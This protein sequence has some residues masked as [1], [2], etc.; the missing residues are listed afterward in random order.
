MSAAAGVRSSSPRNF[1][2]FTAR[3]PNRPRRGATFPSAHQEL[4]A[5]I[6]LDL[7]HLSFL[8][9]YPSHLSAE[10][11]LAAI[12]GAGAASILSREKL[13]WE[14]SAVSTFY[15]LPSRP[16]LGERFA[17]Y[18]KTLFPGLDWGSQRWSEL[19]DALADVAGKQPDVYVVYREEL[20]EGEDTTSALS[21]GFGALAGD[22]VVEILSGEKPSELSTLRWRLGGDVSSVTGV[23][24][25]RFR[26]AG[27]DR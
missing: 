21:D 6:L 26:S 15:L 20:P 16:A 27:K 7:A 24:A 13:P 5:A 2:E 18:L 17:G 11:C 4:A 1:N 8:P 10:S 23:A 19:A 14:G 12:D 22:E 9:A 3:P 25:T